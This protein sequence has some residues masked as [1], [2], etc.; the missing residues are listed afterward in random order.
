MF[1]GGA[2]P[3]AGLQLGAEAADVV[4]QPAG[5]VLPRPQPGQ[6]EQPLLV[7]AALDDAGH[8]P[9]VLTILVGVDLHLADVEAEVVEPA[10]P[11]LDAPQLASVE[12]LGRR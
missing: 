3:G 6:R 2:R 11:L 7:V 12:L 4:E 5:L 1:S 10:Q 9:Q 8:E